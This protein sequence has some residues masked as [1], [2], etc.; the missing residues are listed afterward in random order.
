MLTYWAR[1]F[2]LHFSMR[3]N[4][5]EPGI[6]TGAG[7]V[8]S[9]DLHTLT[10][11]TFSSWSPLAVLHGDVDTVQQ[12]QV[13]CQ[14]V[15]SHLKRLC[16]HHISSKLVWLPSDGWNDKNSIIDQSELCILLTTF[17]CLALVRNNCCSTASACCVLWIL[18]LKKDHVL[19]IT[20]PGA[21][22]IHITISPFHSALNIIYVFLSNWQVSTAQS[23]SWLI[24]AHYSCDFYH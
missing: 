9:A 13:E 19:L 23:T 14:L 24:V 1:Y 3:S 7:H 16:P 12:G 21:H 6:D 8:V 5:L 15:E 2:W 20:W 22:H 11:V 10:A 4:V 17:N 18:L